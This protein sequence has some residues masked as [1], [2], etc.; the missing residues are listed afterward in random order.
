MPARPAVPAQS[1][2]NVFNLME[3]LKDSLGQSKPTATSKSKL[4]K[5][6]VA[7]KAPAKRAKSRGKSMARNSAGLMGRGVQPLHG[8]SIAPCLADETLGERVSTL[9][10]PHVMRRLVIVGRAELDGPRC[11]A[12]ELQ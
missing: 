12:R 4:T 11:V 10:L 5:R 1:P 6:T 8:S 2:K 9:V 7:A 3:A